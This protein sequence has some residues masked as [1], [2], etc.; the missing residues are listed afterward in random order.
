[1]DRLALGFTNATEFAKNTAQ[2]AQLDTG[3]PLSVIIAD[4]IQIL[5]GFVGVLF[6]LYAL[7]AGYVWMTSGGDAEKIKKAKALLINA[8]I[9]ILLVMTAYSI[10]YF[11]ARTIESA[12]P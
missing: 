1:M 11:I 12:L 8:A 7:Y 10:T 2:T 9:G 6:F 4:A 3:Q 5:L